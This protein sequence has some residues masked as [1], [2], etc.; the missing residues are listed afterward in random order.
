[1]IGTFDPGPDIPRNSRK[2]RRLDDIPLDGGD[3]ARLMYSGGGEARLFASEEILED[4]NIEIQDGDVTRLLIDGIISIEFSKRV[5]SLAKKSLDQTLVVMVWIRLPGLP[6]P[7]YKKS[8]IKEIGES[9][10]LVAKLDY[11]TELGRRGRFSRMKISV[12]LSKPL[13]SKIIVNGKIQLI[14]YELLPVICFHCGKYGHA[15]ENCLDQCSDKLM[16]NS[17]MTQTVE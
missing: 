12:D 3:G 14:E 15:K 6:V 10:G 8:L 16:V 2:Q 11:Q 5:Q 9:I 7:L 4:G 1:M 17:E 13:I